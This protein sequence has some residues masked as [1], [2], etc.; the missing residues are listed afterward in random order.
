MEYA[1]IPLTDYLKSFDEYKELLVLNPDE[2]VRELEM[3]DEQKEVEE[4]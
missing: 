1:I 4:L 3:A 2:Y